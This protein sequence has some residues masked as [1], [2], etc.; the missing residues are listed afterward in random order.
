MEDFSLYLWRN[1][2]RS[3]A[4]RV[5]ELGSKSSRRLDSL[6]TIVLFSFMDGKPWLLSHD[7]WVG[8]TLGASSTTSWI[9]G[10]LLSQ[11]TV[12]CV[13]G[14]STGIQEPN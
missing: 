7:M 8:M 10:A 2:D 4:V 9:R 3:A 13:G 1:K 5:A 14:F 6:L 11:E 12:A